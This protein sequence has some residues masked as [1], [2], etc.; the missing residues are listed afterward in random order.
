MRALILVVIIV[1]G[2]IFLGGAVN[3]G[4]APLFTHVDS[5]LGTD[6]LMQLHYGIFSMIYRGEKTV[7][8]GLEQTKEDVKDFSKKPLGIDHQKKYRQLDD[9]SKN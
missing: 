5:M 3:L 7:G 4:S 1:L 8:S 2:I 6:A 9:A